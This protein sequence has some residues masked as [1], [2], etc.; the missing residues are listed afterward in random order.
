[1]AACPGSEFR[2]YGVLGKFHSKHL[3][4]YAC[5]PGTCDFLL[6]GISCQAEDRGVPSAFDVDCQPGLLAEFRI[7]EGFPVFPCVSECLVFLQ[8]QEPGT[9]L[10]LF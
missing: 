5:F 7:L 2:V 10:H 6:Q 1:M 8:R 3:D 9:K 4:F